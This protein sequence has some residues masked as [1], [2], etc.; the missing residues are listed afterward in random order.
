MPWVHVVC[1]GMRTSK[2]HPNYCGISPVPHM[3]WKMST[4][5]NQRS[6]Q[7]GVFKVSPG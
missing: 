1:L 4:R 6:V 3:Y 5:L 2:V 7:G